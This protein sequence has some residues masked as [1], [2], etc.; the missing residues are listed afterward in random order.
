MAVCGAGLSDST[1]ASLAGS[2]NITN[3]K[4][5]SVEITPEFKT[6]IRTIFMTDNALA[7]GDRL[8]AYNSYLGCVESRREALRKEQEAQKNTQKEA[9]V[10]ACLAKLECDAARHEQLCIC[11]ET[12]QSIAEEKSWS[13]QR[14]AKQYIHSCGPTIKG[15]G[16]CFGS[17]DTVKNRSECEVT[18]SEAG[19]TL[20]S[21]SACKK[22]T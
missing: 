18:V 21:A 6:E 9:K 13:E 22:P 1:K 19:R 17:G 5:P 15:I 11:R 8:N 12:V 2:Y 14:M 4:N 10:N 7:E 3:L 16:A 20:P